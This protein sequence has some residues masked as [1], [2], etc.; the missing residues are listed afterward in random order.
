MTRLLPGV[1]IL[2]LLCLLVLMTIYPGLFFGNNGGACNPDGDFEISYSLYT[3]WKSSGVFAI[4]IKIGSL[5][6]WQAKFLD[7]A[8][9]VVS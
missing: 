3:P 1:L 4:N 9:D 2:G 8:W 5:T 6:F 7:V